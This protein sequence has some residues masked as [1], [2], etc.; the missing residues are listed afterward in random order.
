MA[1]NLIET[2]QQEFNQFQQSNAKSNIHLVSQPAIIQNPQM[3]IPPPGSLNVPPPPP[4]HI[5]Q[6]TN[7]IIQQPPPSIIQNQNFIQSHNP[8]Q[9]PQGATI[10]QQQSTIIS[11]PHMMHH[12]TTV[13][14][15][16]QHQPTTIGNLNIPPPGVIPLRTTTVQL[17]C[18]PP[19]PVQQANHLSQPPPNIQIQ[20]QQPHVVG[21]T[22]ILLN[23]QNGQPQYQY[24]YIQQNPSQ[25]HHNV[26]TGAQQQVTIQHLIQ[27][28]QLN[29]AAAAAP[30]NFDQYQ[31]QT[32]IRAQHLQNG[33]QIL[34]VQGNAGFMIPP[35]NIQVHPQQQQPPPTVHQQQPHQNSQDFIF[36]AQHAMLHHPPPST[37]Q[38]Q[39][40][41]NALTQEIQSLNGS[42]Q[43]QMTNMNTGD[44]LNQQ[45]P[46][47]KENKI[48]RENEQ[49]SPSKIDSSKG[50]DGKNN[51]GLNNNINRNVIPMP[52]S[53]SGIPINQPP[54]PIISL[55]SHHIFENTIIAQSPQ[56]QQQQLY[57]QIPVSIQS[58]QPQQPQQQQFF[59][60]SQQ[61]QP[62]V[63]QQQQPIQHLH[64]N[65]NIQNIHF[66]TRNANEIFISNPP[67]M[68]NTNNSVGE[69]RNNSVPP[70][71]QQQQSLVTTTTFNQPMQC[72]PGMQLQF[73]QIQQP[74][75][76]IMHTIQNQ[77]VLDQNQTQ[78]QLMNQTSLKP[79]VATPPPNFN[80]MENKM[81]PQHYPNQ[82]N[83][84]KSM[85]VS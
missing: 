56:H 46:N 4:P 29:Q 44:D 31:Q 78:S 41:Q 18:P 76:Q 84:M 23:P 11:N 70:H 81:N 14:P 48:D 72:P 42:T 49:Q 59:L 19:M 17:Q 22:Q 5:I 6:T 25:L 60:N 32:N 85:T 80:S 38:I 51:V 8:Q 57:S 52:V 3:G 24:Q 21:S 27:P 43:M 33:Q 65:S 68:T 1:K 62:V 67:I 61:W 50:E 47:N 77:Q 66:T 82:G 26:N 20:T 53:I 15:Q 16:I 83:N 79:I 40:S 35:P 10:M 64:Q 34:T 36:H 63:P 28:Q 30:Q 71:Q 9:P 58:F 37:S 39:I 7:G 13:I 73:H 74:P 69:F 45:P 75:P 54:P 12:Q 55:P 2:L